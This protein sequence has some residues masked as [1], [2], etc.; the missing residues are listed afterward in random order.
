[1]KFACIIV[2]I[3]PSPESKNCVK[4]LLKTK[5]KMKIAAI[6]IEQKKL[7]LSDLKYRQILNDVAG[8]DSARFLAPGDIIKVY[9]KMHNMA[10]AHSR[11]ARY[12]WVLWK[13]L[14]LYL[15]S[16]ERTGAWICGFI[17]R[18]TQVQL[19][20]LTSLDDL[21]PGDMHKAIEAI[22]HRIEYEKEKMADVPF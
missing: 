6:K 7:G 12:F 4:K 5:S 8:V 2:I 13:E 16:A 1:M 11:A 20:D 9:R 18:A 3:K 22:K 15:E 10:T 19:E 14:Q 21:A 17:R